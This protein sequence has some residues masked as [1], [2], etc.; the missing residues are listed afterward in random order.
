MGMSIATI[1][2]ITFKDGRAEQSNFDTYR[3]RAW[4]SAPLDVRVHIVPQRLDVPPGG[5]G[6]PGVPPFAPALCNAIF[7]A[8][9]KRIRRCRSA[10]RTE[11]DLS[12]RLGAGTT[13]RPQRGAPPRPRC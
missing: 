5:V 7:A 9:G 10:S 2:E 11:G 12:L 1:G 6:E 3:W 8:T 13:L 4:T